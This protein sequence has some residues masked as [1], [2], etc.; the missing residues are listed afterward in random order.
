[1]RVKFFA[2][3]LQNPFSSG[4]SAKLIPVISLAA[5]IGLQP[6]QVHGVGVAES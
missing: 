2:Q 6:P 5:I 1:M 3:N 4:A